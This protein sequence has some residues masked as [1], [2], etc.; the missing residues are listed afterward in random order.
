MAAYNPHEFFPV[1]SETGYVIGKATRERC[2]DGSKLLHP[3]VHLHVISSQ[4]ELLMQKRPAHKDIQPNKWDT[5]VGGHIDFGETAPSALTREAM[6]EIGIQGFEAKWICS[7]VFESEREREWV[8]CFVCQYDGPFSIAQDEV[9]EAK[10]WSLSEIESSLG[11]SVFTP[12]FEQEFV[13]IQLEQYL[14]SSGNQ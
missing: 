13:R 5:A 1:L 12:N 9:D 3:V 6:E 2:H 7:Y 11:K 4:G 10:F 8:N 14:L